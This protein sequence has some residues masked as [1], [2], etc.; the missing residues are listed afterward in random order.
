MLKNTK[1]K[2]RIMGSFLLFIVL[3]TL[4]TLFSLTGLKS[5]SSQF[6]TFIEKEY[7]GSMAMKDCTIESS[8]MSRV[9]RDM[10]LADDAADFAIHR[11]EYVAAYEMLTGNLAALSTLE[12]G[13]ATDYIS[14]VTAW[15]GNA[16]LVVEQLDKGDMDA[17]QIAIEAQT[18]EFNTLYNM[19]IGRAHV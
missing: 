6:S 4:L 7:K 13:L 8:K 14:A 17:A 10:L 3:A 2:T 11:G 15:M 12:G 1:I 18:A 5:A 9:Q 19:E 16:N